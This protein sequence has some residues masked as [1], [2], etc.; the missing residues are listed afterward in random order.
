MAVR[1]GAKQRWQTKRGLPG[2]RRII[3]WIVL[4]TNA[5][6][7]PEKDRDNFGEALGLVDYDFRWHVGDRFTLVSNGIFDFFP[8]G[9]QIATIGGFLNR[10]PKGGLY[11]GFHSLEGPINSQVVLA[12]YSIATRSL[13]PG[14][15]ASRPS[16]C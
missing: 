1:F 13:R 7:F 14:C 10:P 8:D 2:Q 4:D 6:W 3:D 15:V 16:R 11:V 9:Q 12:S 5:T